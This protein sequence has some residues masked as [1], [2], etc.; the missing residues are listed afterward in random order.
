LNLQSEFVQLA[1]HIFALFDVSLHACMC[2]CLPHDFRYMIFFDSDLSIHMCLIVQVTSLHFTYSLGY[3]L[4]SPGPARPDPGAWTI[5]NPFRGVSLRIGSMVNQ[6]QLVCS[7]SL[8]APS[9]P[10]LEIPCCSSWVSFVL[11]ILVYLFV[12]HNLHLSVI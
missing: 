7:S 3:F 2:L 9:W 5:V 10:T 11:F 6:Q 12:Y 8:P 4:K 1:L